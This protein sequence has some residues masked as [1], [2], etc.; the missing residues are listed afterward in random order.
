MTCNTSAGTVKNYG[1]VILIIHRFSLSVFFITLPERVRAVIGTVLG[2]DPGSVE[3]MVLCEGGT[4]QAGSLSFSSA[5]AASI[6]S[7]SYFW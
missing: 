3:S 2:T 7:S 4:F 1:E 5:W 6:S